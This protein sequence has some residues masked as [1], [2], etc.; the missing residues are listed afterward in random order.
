MDYMI[1]LETLSTEKNALILSVGAVKFEKER[2]S[3]DAPVV[4]KRFYRVLELHVNHATK[5]HISDSTL[6]WWFQ[7]DKAIQDEI[8]GADFPNAYVVSPE[9][10]VNELNSFLSPT[11]NA[12]DPMDNRD[13]VWANAPG[14]DLDILRTH[15]ADFRRPYAIPWQFWQE[16]DVRTLKNLLPKE[17]LPPRTGAHNALQDALWQVHIVQTI[18][19]IWKGAMR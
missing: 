12:V 8:F 7:Q 19:N 9:D 18:Y 2:Y 10:L 4:E 16:R 15:Y 6:R 3:P 17:K 14:F 13:T 5:R 11:G 1:D